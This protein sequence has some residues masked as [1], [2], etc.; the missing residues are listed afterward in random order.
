[1][2]VQKN[3]WFKNRAISD[4]Y[5]PGSVMKT[6]T[7]A[8]GIDLGILSPDSTY[9]SKPYK[10]GDHTITTADGKYYGMSTLTDMLI[11]SDNTGAAK[12]G[13]EIGREKFYASLHKIGFNR[14]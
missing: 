3:Q 12:F 4:A 10:V 5:E 7:A 13:T 6:F 8:T 11:H 1:E 2:E 14:P 9:E